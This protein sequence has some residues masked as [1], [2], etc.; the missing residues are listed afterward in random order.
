MEEALGF[1]LHPE[2]AALLQRHNGVAEQTGWQSP[3]FPAGSFLPLGHRLDTTRAI[4]AVHQQLIE[5]EKE[6]PQT[7]FWAEDDVNGHRHQWVSF[8]HPNDGGLAFIDH[9]PGPTYGHVYEFGLGSGAVD[10]I[11]WAPSLTQ[12]IENLTTCL[13]DGIP[14][15]RF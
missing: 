1:A 3:P 9:R 10:P 7:E 14:F 12:F 8:A 13:T 15:K 4:A 6:Y 5:L 11:E 2:L